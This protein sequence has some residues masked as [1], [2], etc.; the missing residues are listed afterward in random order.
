MITLYTLNLHNVICQ[1]YLNGTGKNENA[2]TYFKEKKSQGFFFSPCLSY[3]NCSWS[4]K[5]VDEGK[6]LFGEVSS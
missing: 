4:Y 3:T 2:L 1:L 5:I 6:L